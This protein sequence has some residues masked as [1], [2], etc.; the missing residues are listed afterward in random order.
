MAYSAKDLVIVMEKESGIKLSELKCDGGASSNDL[1]MQFQSDVL[2]VGVN[3]PREKESTALG[4]VYLCA[5][6]LNLIKKEDISDL[7]ECEKFFEPK[8]DEVKYGKLYDGWKRAV[9]RCL[10]D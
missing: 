6:G 7:R 8:Y 1:L 10:H 2:G 3:R 4:A 5:L 9:G